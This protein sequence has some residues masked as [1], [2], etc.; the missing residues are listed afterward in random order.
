MIL[1]P[2]KLINVDSDS[3]PKNIKLSGITMIPE[4]KSKFLNDCEENGSSLV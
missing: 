2:P 1:G 3:R 4:N